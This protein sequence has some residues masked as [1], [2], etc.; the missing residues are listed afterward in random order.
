[1]SDVKSCARAGASRGGARP[2]DRRLRRARR[3]CQ[4]VVLRHGFDDF[5]RATRSHTL[6]QPTAHTEVILAT[7]RWLLVTAMPAIERRGVTLVGLS[8]ANL[9]DDAA[10]QLGLPFGRHLASELD[11]TLDD[12][13]DRFGSDAITRAVLVGRDP[14]ITMP[15]LP[16]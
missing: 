16:D 6:P 8:L 11:A 4:T 12:V 3:V 9:E 15:L 10:V 1:M 14:G 7:A 2:V 13:R 5:S